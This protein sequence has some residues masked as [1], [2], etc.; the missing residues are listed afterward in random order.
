MSCYTCLTRYFPTA[1]AEVPKDVP[2]PEIPEISSEMR[3][4]MERR[5]AKEIEF[6]RFVSQKL[7]QDLKM[8][9]SKMT[10]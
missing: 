1:V 9:K 4:E 3:A 8:S 2:G 10:Q 6:Y 5:Y 7:D